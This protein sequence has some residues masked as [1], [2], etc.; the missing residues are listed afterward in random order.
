MDKETETKVK[1][2]V[3]ELLK[4]ALMAVLRTITFKLIGGKKNGRK[5]DR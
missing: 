1:R 4:V 5:Q 2:T 3:S